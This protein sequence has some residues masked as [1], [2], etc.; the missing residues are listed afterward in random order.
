MQAAVDPL[1]PSKHHSIISLMISGAIINSLINANHPPHA[2]RNTRNPE[3]VDRDIVKA[4]WKPVV[5][6][7]H[8]CLSGQNGK[9]KRQLQE[10]LL[11]KCKPISRGCC[12]QKKNSYPRDTLAQPCSLMQSVDAHEMRSAI[13]S[14]L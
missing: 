9:L 4:L 2:E 7:V 11:A 5:T 14:A 1:D 3:E 13:F 6:A 8:K 10:T 12:H